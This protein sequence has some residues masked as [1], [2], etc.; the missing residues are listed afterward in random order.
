MEERYQEIKQYCENNIEDFELKYELALNVIGRMRCDLKY[1]DYNL[2][3]EIYD[4]VEEWFED[5]YILPADYTCIDIDE[6]IS[7]IFD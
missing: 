5:Y 1:A 2:Y 6:I 4:K 7:E 3:M